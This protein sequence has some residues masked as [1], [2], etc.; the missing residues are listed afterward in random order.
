MT[1]RA[2]LALGAIAAVAIAAGLWLV[3]DVRSP[4]S[5]LSAAGALAALVT[6]PS[7][8]PDPPKKL[9]GMYGLFVVRADAAERIFPFSIVPGRGD[10]SDYRPPLSQL[11]DRF[12]AGFPA[13]HDAPDDGRA[14]RNSCVSPA[15]SDLGFARLSGHLRLRA[16]TACVVRQTGTGPG[17]ML[18]SVTIADARPWTRLFVRRV[19]RQLTAGA[20]AS[21]GN[22]PA[23][24]YAACVLVDRPGRIRPGDAQATFKSIVYQ[25]RDRALARID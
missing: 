7:G 13:R 17:A 16:Q 9:A 2:K 6:F 3:H 8:V 20:L 11:H 24:D 1:M 15:A 18:V 21:L 23:P 19:C 5:A 25:V 22:A 12:E 14:G 4:R 10:L